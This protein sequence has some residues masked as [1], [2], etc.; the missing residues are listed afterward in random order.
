MGGY[1]EGHCDRPGSQR[2]GGGP[3]YDRADKGG[4][5]TAACW[6]MGCMQVSLSNNPE[7]A[8]RLGISDS[9]LQASWT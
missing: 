6:T 1:G 4:R 3:R 9:L 7:G 5:G 8:S 2:S